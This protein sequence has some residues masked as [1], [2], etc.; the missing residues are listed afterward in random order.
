MMHNGLTKITSSKDTDNMS[1]AV[2]LGNKVLCMYVD[3][4]NTIE[5]SQGGGQVVDDDGM[6]LV[7]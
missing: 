6:L 5:Q 1:C 4:D 2:T 3:T 7:H